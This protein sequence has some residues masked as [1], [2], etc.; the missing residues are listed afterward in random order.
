MRSRTLII[1]NIIINIINLPVCNSWSIYNLPLS[2][3]FLHKQLPFPY[4]DCDTLY[5]AH[6]CME[7]LPISLGFWHPELALL[8]LL[9]LPHSLSGY[10]LAQMTSLFYKESDILHTGPAAPCVYTLHASLGLEPLPRTRAHIGQTHPVC[11]GQKCRQ[12]VCRQT[13]YSV[14]LL[15]TIY[16]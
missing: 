6:F 1:L 4:W 3:L 15:F 5:Q 8:I 9:W 7:V 2:P 10:L 12:R 13:T 11:F 14:S 16:D